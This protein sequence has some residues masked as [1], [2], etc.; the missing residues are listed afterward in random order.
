[1]G[2]DEKMSLIF[3]VFDENRSWYFKENMQRSARKSYNTTNPEFYESNVIYSINGIM[4]SGRQFVMCETD[5]R[6][7]HVANVGTGSE[8]LSIYFT[9]NLFQHQGLYQ[10]VLTLFPMTA[11]T[12]PMETEMIGEIKSSHLHPFLN[13]NMLAC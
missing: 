6:F 13:M 9:G 12:I 7:W 2:L 10:S 11:V 3:G 8:F 1:L 5:V 4:F